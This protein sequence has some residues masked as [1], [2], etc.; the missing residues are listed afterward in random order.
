MIEPATGGP[1]RLRY[2]DFILNGIA[3]GM[4][5]GFGLWMAAEFLEVLK[6]S[7]PS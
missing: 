4:S 6:R 5:F 1:G 7:M 3:W 2:I